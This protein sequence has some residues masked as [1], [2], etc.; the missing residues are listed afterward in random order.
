MTFMCVAS[1][2]VNFVMRCAGTAI[3]FGGAFKRQLANSR[4][5]NNL[6]LSQT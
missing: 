5:V 2:L 1:N 3:A 4:K 6:N